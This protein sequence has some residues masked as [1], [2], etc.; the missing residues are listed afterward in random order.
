MSETCKNCKKEIDSGI[1]MSP[2]FKEEK[3]LS[4]CSE[5]CKE[6]YLRSKLESLKSSYPKYYEKIIKDPKQVL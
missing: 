4:F 2:Q 1:F 3:V 6:E 5:K